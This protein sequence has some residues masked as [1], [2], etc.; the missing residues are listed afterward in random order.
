M[1]LVL[2]RSGRRL[3][4]TKKMHQSRHIVLSFD[5]ARRERADWVRLLGYCGFHKDVNDAHRAGANRLQNKQNLEENSLW[6]LWSLWW[7][8]WLAVVEVEVEVAVAVAVVVVVVVVVA[9]AVVVVE[10]LIIFKII[11]IVSGADFSEM[12]RQLSKVK[13]V[14]LFTS[15]EN[16]HFSLEKPRDPKICC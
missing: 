8:L 13:C 2:E 15:N 6:W 5:G 4:S 14:F 1:I 16:C 10:W 11:N 7:L 3:I 12:F 9:V